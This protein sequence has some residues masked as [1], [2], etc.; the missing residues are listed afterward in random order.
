MNM[1]GRWKSINY[2]PF[3]LEKNWTFIFYC[4]K[5]IARQ[6]LDTVE[7]FVKNT[8][9][10]R[11]VLSNNKNVSSS[12]FEQSQFEQFTPTQFGCILI[13][14]IETEKKISAATKFSHFF[15]VKVRYGWT[16]D[17]LDR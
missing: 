17:G 8:S 1:Y 5:K 6:L 9:T 15:V 4:R 11:T 12:F 14:K 7:Q 2:L 13:Q 3:L 10:A 16:W